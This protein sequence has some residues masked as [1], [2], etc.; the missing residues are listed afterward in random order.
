MKNKKM[1]WKFIVPTVSIILVMTILSVFAVSGY[2][3]NQ[4]RERAQEQ[5]SAKVE[6]ISQSLDIVNT[7]MIERV[8]ASIRLLMSEG[9]T[10]GAPSLG[11]PVVVAS[12]QVPGLLLGNK[13]QADNFSLVDHVKSVM[14]G[15]ATLFVKNGSDFVRVSTNVIKDD[16]SRAVGTVLDPQGKAIAA[17]RESKA[18]YGQ[19]DILGKPYLTGY[20]PMHDKTGNIVGV[21]YVGYPISA[22]TQLGDAI[23]KTKILDNGFVALIDDHGKVRFGS[24]NVTT[25]YID[26]LL[27]KANVS[28]E[29]AATLETG[30]WTLIRQS[31]A[32]WGFQVV[33]AYPASDIDRKIYK[34]VA[35]VILSGLVIIGILT[36][37]LV[38]L[39][40]RK[41]LMPIKT[42]IGAADH[43]SK[44]NMNVDINV[45]SDD[46]TGQLI[47]A[48]NEIGRNLRNI[49]THTRDASYGVSSAADQIAAA[50][51][52]FSARVAEQ[53]ASLEETSTTMEEMSA[54]VKQTAENVKEASTLALSTKTLADSGATVM[55]EAIKA[56]D[57]INKSSGKIAS[58]SGVIEEIAFQTNLLALNAAVEAARAGEHGKG[59][60]VVATEIRSL[61]QRASQSAKEITALIEDSLGKT[62]RGVRLSRE[63]DV[64]LEEIAG[65]VKRVSDL[66]D[67]VAAAA[68]EQTSGISQITTAMTQI[69]QTTQMNASFI[70]DTAT[71]ADELA[72]QARG[73]KEIISFFKLGDTEPD[74]VRRKEAD[75]IPALKSYHP[76]KDKNISRPRRNPA[77]G[78][79]NHAAPQSVARSGDGEPSDGGFEGY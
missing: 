24:Q 43:L 60:A 10:S 23:A 13:P 72:S 40:E 9:L 18:F 55:S 20:E 46:E 49:I 12:Q 14:G 5:I 52:D 27:K 6:Q 1:I 33:A 68:E 37:S 63:L 69:D 51:Q 29:K 41:I 3:K 70:D 47:S 4:I 59:F 50:N 61:A 8:H 74:N 58:I 25:E 16:G 22:L 56:M 28:E 53:A 79:N 75:E 21:W 26:A 38:L 36:A 17:I 78:N 11:P 77:F 34:A 65:G 31:Y 48:I 42:T 7:V 32:P 44:G 39:I 66:M 30:G 19:V 73:L 35:I 71:A 15:T 54:T 62:E 76:R 64:K 2:I 45:S 57:E 67:E